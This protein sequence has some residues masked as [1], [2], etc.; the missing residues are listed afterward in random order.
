MTRDE[1]FKDLRRLT[2]IYG[3]E[4]VLAGMLWWMQRGSGR[5]AAYS[6][7]ILREIEDHAKVYKVDEK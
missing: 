6:I 7:R 4:P 3:T 1:F 2:R 5:K